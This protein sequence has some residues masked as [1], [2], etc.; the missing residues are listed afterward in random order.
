LPRGCAITR[1]LQPQVLVCLAGFAVI[2]I[3]ALPA[4]AAG[5]PAQG[6]AVPALAAFD[7]VMQ[8][9]MEKNGISAGQLAITR[10]EV[11]VFERSYG[12]QDKERTKP[13]LLGAPMRI[14]SVTKPF[15]AA[16]IRA[17][18]RLSKGKLT[19]KTRVFSFRKGDGGILNFDPFPDHV[20]PDSRLKDITIED[21]LRHRG[22]W[23]RNH[24]RGLHRKK[25]GDL[26][27]IELKIAKAMNI[28]SPPG[29]INTVRYI[30]GQPLQF[31]PGSRH[32]YSN[33]GYLVLGLVIKK[34]LAD[35]KGVNIEEISDDDYLTFLRE[36]VIRPAGIVDSD[37]ILGRSL[38]ANADPREPYYDNPT[39]RQSVFPP[40]GQ[41]EAPY[42]SFDLEARTGQGR[43]VTNARSI[44]RFLNK[45][46]PNPPKSIGEPRIPNGSWNFYHDGEQRGAEA[47][48]R[49]RGEGINYAVIFNKD[50]TGGD[51]E[52]DGG[53]KTYAA[54][55]R[56]QLDKKIV[57]GVIKW[58]EDLK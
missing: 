46:M 52:D 12:W 35:E 28:P 29:P 31:T 23:D 19:L 15:T 49:A 56:Q 11:L 55:I 24:R 26:T 58:P 38:R 44:V 57:S 21:C 43:I 32:A 13:L 40:G 53:H 14:A 4:V 7:E 30:L 20:K 25:V 41:V 5:P 10:N 17:L 6:P 8:K 47:L 1:L 37:L 22:G 50:K 9:F 48:A 45:F 42:G 2:G 39:K 51:D 33:I 34:V 18:I 54:Q 27:Y 3:S 36:N 16:A